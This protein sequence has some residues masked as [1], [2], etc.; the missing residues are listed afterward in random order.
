MDA[1][2]DLAADRANGAWNPLLATGTGL[3]EARRLCDDALLG[4]R[5][6]LGETEFRDGRLVH[7]LLVHELTRSVHRVFAGVARAPAPGAAGA[8]EGSGAGRWR[9]RRG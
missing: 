4:I 7:A 2:E 3:A 9:C 5:L 6:A 8:A 1:V